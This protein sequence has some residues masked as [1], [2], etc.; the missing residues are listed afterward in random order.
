MT[1]SRDHT[2][3]PTAPPPPALCPWTISP[4]AAELAAKKLS[5]ANLESAVE[6]LQRDGVILLKQAR[7]RQLLARMQS[8][9]AIHPCFSSSWLFA[10]CICAPVKLVRAPRPSHVG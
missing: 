3:L 7:R 9:D 10:G 2:T 6:G 1:A 5:D 8:L 4:T